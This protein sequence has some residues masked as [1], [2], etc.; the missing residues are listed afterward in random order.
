MPRLT[1]AYNTSKNRGRVENT[2]HK[3]NLDKQAHF[4]DRRYDLISEKKYDVKRG[5]KQKSC[6]VYSGIYPVRT[7]SMQICTNPQQNRRKQKQQKSQLKLYKT[8]AVP[9]IMYW[10]DIWVT[11]EK[12]EQRITHKKSISQVE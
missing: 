1:Y 6:M 9:T 10:N 11:T 4:T 2:K 8:I 5:Q 12:K 3:T 7:K